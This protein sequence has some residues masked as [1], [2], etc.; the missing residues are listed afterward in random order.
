MS[1][2]IRI[3]RICKHCGNS[4]IAKT[5]VTKYCGDDC[6]KKAY[7]LRKKKEKVNESYKE[8]KNIKKNAIENLDAKEF[9]T[10]TQTAK[11]INCSRQNVY[12]LINSGRLPSSNLLLKK[13]LIRRIDIDDLID[14]TKTITNHRVIE[15]R[16]RKQHSD[17]TDLYSISQIQNK[18][19]ISESALQSI[20]KRNNLPRYRH[21]RSVFISKLIIED[22]LK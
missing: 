13:T 1:S 22:I 9:L 21:G 14:N 11:L 4:F 18:F 6:A 20:I 5:T 15:N 8:T 17:Y 2:N 19:K 7:K 16:S 3:E 10:V 12:K